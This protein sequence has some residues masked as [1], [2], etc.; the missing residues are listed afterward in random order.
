MSEI[1]FLEID[2]ICRTTYSYL[3]IQNELNRSLCLLSEIYVNAMWAKE[4]K[5]M[6]CTVAWLLG[7][8]L[9]K[10]FFAMLLLYENGL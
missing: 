9:Q 7:A 10:M 8:Y 4:W 3:I 2:T 6:P 5:S 1:N